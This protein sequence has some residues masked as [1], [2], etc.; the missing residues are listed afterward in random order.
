MDLEVRGRWAM[1]LCTRSLRN[2]HKT[3]L[4]PSRSRVV[5][6]SGGGLCTTAKGG[7]A[8]A[9][10][11][12][13]GQVGPVGREG[14][15][16]AANGLGD[17]AGHLD[18]EGVP[19]AQTTSAERIALAAAGVIAMALLAGQRFHGY[20]RIRHRN[21]ITRRVVLR[22]QGGRIG[23][24]TTKSDEKIQSRAVHLQAKIIGHKAMATQPV[25]GEVVLQFLVT[26]LA[27]AAFD[28]AVVAGFRQHGRPGSVGHDKPPVGA[29]VVALGLDDHPARILPAFGP[30]EE[31]IKHTNRLA[32]LFKLLDR[33]L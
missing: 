10:M 20:G 4:P 26:V 31:L 21:A 13:P 8:L 15:S 5:A 33:L 12:E 29:Q 24:Q 16:D 25:A 7:D 19:R 30:V 32:R 17:L 11:P 2:A 23:D 14:D 9:D 22:G 28:I 1:V 18:E 6:R 27:F 3:P